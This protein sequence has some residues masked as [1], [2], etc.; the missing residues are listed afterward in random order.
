[1]SR[2]ETPVPFEIIQYPNRTV[3]ES[4]EESGLL[5]L[6]DFG[7]KAESLHVRQQTNPNGSAED[8]NEEDNDNEDVTD[9]KDDDE[10]EDDDDDDL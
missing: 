1:M 7:L 6:G 9:I 10:D 2:D 3:G 5:T 8:D 4:G